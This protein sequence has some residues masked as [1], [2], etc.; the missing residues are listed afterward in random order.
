MNDALREIGEIVQYGMDQTIFSEGEP[1]N[2]LY[3]LLSGKLLV[4][5][6]GII[7]GEQIVLAELEKGAVFGE[8]AV[9]RDHFRSATI[10]AFEPCIAL[11]IPRENFTRFIMLEPRYTINMLKTLS[12]RINLAREKCNERQGCA[13]AK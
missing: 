1:G 10:T 13:D 3:I 11:K 9:I 4:T 7:D 2:A 12:V 5:K 6:Q 8:M